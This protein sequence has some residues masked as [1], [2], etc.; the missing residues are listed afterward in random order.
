MGWIV[1]IALGLAGCQLFPGAQPAM[2]TLPQA[3]E[4][5][6]VLHTDFELSPDHR[7]LREVKAER[8]D[9]CRVLDMPPSDE[10]IH[11]HLFEQEETYRQFVARHFPDVPQ[12]RA[13]FLETDTRL[14]VFAIWSDRVSD[15]LRHELAH[16]YLH[17]SV[18]NLPLWLDEGLA[19]FFE[20]PR[21]Q[22]GLN[23][24]HV[25]LLAS[26]IENDWRPDMSQ[27]ER[28]KTAG[29]M[30]QHHYAESWAWVHFL[31]QTEPERRELLCSY[32]ETLRTDGSAPPLSEKVQGLVEGPEAALTEYL[33]ALQKGL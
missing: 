22:Q 9:I 30:Q 14:A 8:G 20:V 1:V 23:V 2:T 6:L 21:G 24:P 16:G 25:E 29:E 4:G 26:M 17:A 3:D 13:F 31:L 15:D 19:E 10:P 18:P 28:L 11:V 5:Q 7:L 27:L 12:R 32:L 33:L